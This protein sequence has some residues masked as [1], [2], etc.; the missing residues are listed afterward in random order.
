VEPIGAQEWRSAVSKRGNLILISN[1]GRYFAPGEKGLCNVPSAAPA[2]SSVLDLS[3]EKA[4]PATVNPKPKTTS[5]WNYGIPVA[6]GYLLRAETKADGASNEF[7]VSTNF[8]P[9]Q[10]ILSPVTTFLSGLCVE[11]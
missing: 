1:D 4:F 3:F 11:G 6:N 9:M 5:L 7:F 2:R 8:L 10:S